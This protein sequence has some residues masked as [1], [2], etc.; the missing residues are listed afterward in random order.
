MNK[1]VRKKAHVVKTTAGTTTVPR[2]LHPR[3]KRLEHS[4]RKLDATLAEVSQ[5]VDE[6][7]ILLAIYR[8]PDRLAALEKAV[9]ALEQAVRAG[10]GPVQ[11]L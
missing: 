9:A 4:R 2:K 7:S 1:Q 6:L 5:K 11:S 10:G 3:I 8:I